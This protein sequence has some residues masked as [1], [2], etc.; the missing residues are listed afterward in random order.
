MVGIRQRPV[1]SL[2]EQ[3]L[4]PR[5]AHA[6]PVSEP[7]PVRARLFVGVGGHRG[8][9]AVVQS[10][11]VARKNTPQF[12]P[13]PYPL[14]LRRALFQ[15]TFIVRFQGYAGIR[16]DGPQP[17]Q[18]QPLIIAGQRLRRHVFPPRHPVGVLQTAAT[19]R[20]NG[21]LLGRQKLQVGH[22]PA[23]VHTM[24]DCPDVLHVCRVPRP[25]DCPAI[26]HL[27]VDVGVQRFLGVRTGRRH[28]VINEPIRR[29][30]GHARRLLVQI[31]P[32]RIHLHP[33]EVCPLGLLRVALI[34]LPRLFPFVFRPG[35][36]LLDQGLKELLNRL[37]LGR[38]LGVRF[39]PAEQP[40]D[41][42][43]NGHGSVQ[44]ARD[45]VPVVRQHLHQ[46]IPSV[47]GR[48]L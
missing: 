6:V 25:C 28:R 35:L 1:V 7:L 27:A 24:H 43:Q 5:L 26:P 11:L 4:S 10:V 22:H 29:L 40:H 31:R 46:Q 21:N 20:V 44:C 37:R 32:L 9:L 33:P 19:I 16:G 17:L 2:D 47:A 48:R 12:A 30:H 23:H 3:H 8:R 15:P 42:I 34:R 36:R 41:V 18:V 14:N 38:G 13:L 39:G 45:R